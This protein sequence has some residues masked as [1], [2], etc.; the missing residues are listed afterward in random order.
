MF[1]CHGPANLGQDKDVRD[2]PLPVEFVAP[3]D[4]GA[5]SSLT[6][7]LGTAVAFNATQPLCIVKREPLGNPDREL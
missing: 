1:L 5:L 2:S 7:P 3:E 6:F 4:D